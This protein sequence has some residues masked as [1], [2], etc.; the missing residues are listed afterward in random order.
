MFTWIITHQGRI[1][2]TQ[3]GVFTIENP[4]PEKPCI[5]QSIAHDGACMS[6]TDIS[7]TT[8]SFFA[9]EES[10]AKT[11]FSHKQPGETFNLELCAQPT[12]RLDGH[13]VTWH[14]DTTGLV[15][16]IQH[17]TDGSRML[18]IRYN[19]QFDAY[20][21]PKG[22]VAING[23]SLTVVDTAPG[24][25]SVRLIPLTLE[26]TNLSSITNGSIVNLE[27]DMLGK[28]VVR[29]LQKTRT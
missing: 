15:D 20:L 1:L 28:Y 26:K 8:Y 21:I 27:F 19:T 13:I 7:A 5:G 17:A 18:W 11:N 2:D 22:S 10:F 14:I 29:Y 6:V 9:M 25:F 3:N 16:T 12:S 23:V 24:Y 4:F